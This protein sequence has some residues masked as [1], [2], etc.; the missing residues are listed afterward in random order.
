[1]TRLEFGK[2]LEKVHRNSHE[3]V[4]K[5]VFRRPWAYDGNKQ[6]PHG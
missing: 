3:I 6:Q 5:F 2:K 4:R 1:M